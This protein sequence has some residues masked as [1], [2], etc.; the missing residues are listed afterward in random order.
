MIGV[1]IA[2]DHPVVRQGIRQIVASTDDIKVVDEATTGH[3]A[4]E[5][6]AASTCDLV[7]LDLSL[8]DIDGLDLLKQL[9]REHPRRP[10]LILT[11]HSEDQFALRALKAGAS[12]YLTKESAPGELVDAVRKVVAG[13]RYIS[14]RLAETLAA[15]LGPDAEKPAHERLSDREYQVLR[16]IAAGR[17][18]RDISA[19]LAL[20]MKTI[21]TYRA[22]LLDKMGMK[23]SAELTAYAVRYH[24]AD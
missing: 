19:Q 4:L 10:I 23:T 1:F 17:S 12:G 15:H 11:M 18:T 16:L 20:S 7:L 5:R 3:E 8:P 21:S 9:R 14:Q 2:D 6:L 24:L 13:G 22:R